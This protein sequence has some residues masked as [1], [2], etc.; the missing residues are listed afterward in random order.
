MRHTFLGKL[1]MD[2][3]LT[4]FGGGYTPTVSGTPSLSL[5]QSIETGA[6]ENLPKRRRSG[7]GR[8]SLCSFMPCRANKH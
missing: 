4:V 5:A 8:P 7:S 1:L 3:R 2:R 6:V